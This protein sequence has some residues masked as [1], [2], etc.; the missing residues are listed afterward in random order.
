MP[1][2]FGP[3]NA[4]T[5]AAL[6]QFIRRERRLK[7]S[8]FRALLERGEECGGVF[9]KGERYYLN[10]RQFLSDDLV[11][12]MQQKAGPITWGEIEALVAETYPNRISI[13]AET[14]SAVE[15]ATQNGFVDYVDAT[16]ELILTEKGKAKGPPSPAEDLEIE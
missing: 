13:N 16:G 15:N 8:E 6:H 5:F 14:D 1:I 4:K 3:D 11:F 12:F 9:R 7:V 10:K 2:G